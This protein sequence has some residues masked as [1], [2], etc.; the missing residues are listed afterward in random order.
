M[1]HGMTVGELAMLFNGEHMGPTDTAIKDTATKD[2]PATDS[3]TRRKIN[4]NNKKINMAPGDRSDNSVRKLR[5]LQVHIV[6]I[7]GAA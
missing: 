7:E 4:N 5:G 3:E 1:V 6:C 2:T